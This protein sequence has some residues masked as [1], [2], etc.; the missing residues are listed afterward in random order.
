MFLDVFMSEERQLKYFF[1][2]EPLLR[3]HL[4]QILQQLGEILGIGLVYS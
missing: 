3:V 2:G 4:Y 1:A